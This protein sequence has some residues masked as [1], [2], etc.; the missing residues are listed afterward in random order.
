MPRITGFH[1]ISL[2]VLDADKSEEF[3]TKAF[4]FVRVIEI[5]DQEGRGFKRVLAH[6]SGMILGFSVHAAN[7]GA[8]FSEFRTGLD[9]FAFTVESR[10]AL[11][12]WAAHL[13]GVGIEHSEI[14]DTGVGNLMTVRDPDNIQ[15]ELWANPE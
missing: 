6:P 13:E 5:P 14:R 15:V 8:S 4:K 3:Y 1:H 12:E 11:D 10:G 7:D 9:H 2:T